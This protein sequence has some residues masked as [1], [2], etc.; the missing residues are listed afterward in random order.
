M[1]S[2]IKIHK[3]QKPDNAKYFKVDDYK[4]LSTII[5][6]QVVFIR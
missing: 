2:N 1:R 6:N 5:E 3:E 4:A